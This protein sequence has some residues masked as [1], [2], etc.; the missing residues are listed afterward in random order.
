M[1]ALLGA[2][3]AVIFS[4]VWIYFRNRGGYRAVPISDDQPHRSEGLLALPSR[5]GQA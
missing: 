3:L 4:G 2:V 5:H 1:V